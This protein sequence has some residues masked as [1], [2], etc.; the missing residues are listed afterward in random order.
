MDKRIWFGRRLRDFLLHLE[1]EYCSLGV[2]T[3]AAALLR[4]LR[5]G[6]WSFWGDEIFSLGNRSDGFVEST[7]VQLIHL[8]TSI[9]GTSEWSARLVP[10]LIG[11][12]SVP[13][14]YF[15]AKRMLGVR[16]ALLAAVL[17]AIS[18]WHLYWSQN[19]RF[20]VLLLL[21]HTLALL[22]FFLGLEE[23]KPVFILLSLVF[24]AMAAKERLLAF[25]FLPVAVLYLICL[26]LFPFEKPAGLRWKNLAIFFAPLGIVGLLFAFPYL[27]NIR[28]WFESFS[29]VNNNPFWLTGSTFYYIGLPTV[30]L[31]AVG[32]FH[33]LMKRSRRA[34]FLALGAAVPLIGIVGLSFFHYTA[35]RYIFVALTSWLFLASMAATE[36]VAALHGNQRI[37]AAGV[38]ALLLGSALSENVLYYQYQHGNRDRWREALQIVREEKSPGDLVVVANTGVGNY[39]LGE[40]VVGFRQL[41][42][43]DLD[44]SRQVWLVEDMTVRQLYPEVHE[45]MEEHTQLVANLDNHFS[46]RVFTMRVYTYPAESRFEAGLESDG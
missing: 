28:G 36:L 9:L 7:T 30:L 14:L 23:D 43:L 18:P 24:F 25:F 31:A 29:R 32:G 17:L 40:E 38:I 15:P 42:Q 45:W 19:A 4:F 22:T 6:E 37:L 11:T 2:I 10:A 16:V 39:Y 27:G 12:L 13:I 41:P 26:R 33:F 35:N 21:F 46:A 3:I 44:Q 5:L 34:L 20:Y 8:T 1:V